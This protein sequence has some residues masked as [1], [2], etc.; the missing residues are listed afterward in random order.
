MVLRSQSRSRVSANGRNEMRKLTLVL[1]CAALLPMTA[2]RAQLFAPN[3]AGVS[4][5]HLHYFVRDIGKNRKFWIDLG[6]T[7]VMLGTREVWRFPGLTVPLTQGNPSGNSEGSVVDHVGFRV[8]N[9][10]G[11]MD[12]MVD[13]GYKV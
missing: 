4:M 11:T 8:P 13:L 7:P 3:V 10:R 2:A 12:R 9:V 1:I 6:A 5:G